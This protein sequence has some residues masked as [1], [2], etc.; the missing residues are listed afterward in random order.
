MD[1]IKAMGFGALIAGCVSVVIGTQGSA[2]GQLAIHSYDVIDFKV[3]WSWP[4]F[5]VSSG[6]FWGLLLLQR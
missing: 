2:G 5:L 1:L 6:L 3:Y 4:A